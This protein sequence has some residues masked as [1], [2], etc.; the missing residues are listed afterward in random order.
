MKKVIYLS[1]MIFLVACSSERDADTIKKEINDKK[2]Q[3]QSLRLDVSELEDELEKISDEND[4]RYKIPVKVKKMK[5]EEF[6]HYFEA[7][8]VVEP[9]VEAF[10]SPEINGQIEEIYVSEGER[11]SKGQKLVRLKTKVTDNTI[12]EVETSLE[13]A[14]T[15]YQKQKKLWEKNIG[16]EVQ[17]LEAKNRL[18]SLESRLETL[19]AQKAMA[20]VKSPI[21]GIVDKIY[22]KEGELSIPGVQ[23]MQVVNLEN[24]LVEVDIA[25]SYLPKIK[26]GDQVLL[27]FP[28]YPG[29]TIE[30]PI[31]RIGNVIEP[32]NRTFSMEL[33]IKN[34]KEMFKPNM[35][36]RVKVNDFSTDSALVVPAII[37]K[38][39][40]KG[41]YVYV[42]E[43][44]DGQLYAKKRYVEPGL[45]YNEITIV[46][47]GLKPG[48][49]VI[50]SGFTQISD[51]S[52]IYVK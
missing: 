6:N 35:V 33:K 5:P 25:E 48:D 9:V 34:R 46:D 52:E 43:E 47:D 30:T 8:G 29:I 15:M 44:N 1:I 7:S 27:D 42:A 28:T 17:Y 12:D 32:D 21:N 40:L 14:R 18:E 24:M 22:K 2:K 19:R 31:Y 49:E 26:T 4:N 45:S 39:D 11:V 38:Q 13:L 10:I 16:S 23:I 41:D 50:T 20:L 37:V 3:I 51:G 36:A